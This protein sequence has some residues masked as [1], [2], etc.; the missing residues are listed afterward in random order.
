M[1]DLNLGFVMP[2]TYNVESGKFEE[3]KLVNGKE[4]DDMD[5]F[6]LARMK[7]ITVG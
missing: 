6:E 2:P 3:P 5:I 7:G 4:E 1:K